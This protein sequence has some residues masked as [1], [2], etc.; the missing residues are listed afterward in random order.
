MRKGKASRILWAVAAVACVLLLREFAVGW[1]ALTLAQSHIYILEEAYKKLQADPAFPGSGFPE[2]E[3]IKANEGV[4]WV[5][6]HA[7]GG[8]LSGPGP[9]ST[10]N[11]DYSW[12][13]YNPNTKK[14]AAPATAARYYIH[15]R[16][17]M[18]H[19]NR[20]A[21][22]PT[23]KGSAAHNA[24]YMAH[25]LA[26]M[27]VPYHLTGMP[28][29]E[30]LA[31]IEAGDFMLGEDIVGP[32]GKGPENWKNVMLAWKN[33]YANHPD[34][35]WFDPWYWNGKEGIAPSHV[36]ATVLPKAI[37]LA[38]QFM[39][40]YEESTHLLWELNYGPTWVGTSG[41]LRG[42]AEGFEPQQIRNGN[43]NPLNIENLAIRSAM[44][45]RQNQKDWWGFF[46]NAGVAD[47]Y[48]HAV[49]NVF[50]AWRASFSALRASFSVEPDPETQENKL[51][52]TVKNVENAETSKNVTIK[53]TVRG[54]VLNGPDHHVLGDL[55]PG[56]EEKIED[57]WTIENPDR[58]TTVLI[59]VTGA[60]SKTPDSGV[61]FKEDTVR[62]LIPTSVD[63]VPS[64]VDRQEKLWKLEISVK[65]FKGQPVDQGD[66]HFRATGGSFAPQ[67]SLLEYQKTLDRGRTVKGWKETDE[68][69]HQI[70]V[71]YL[72]DK[73]DPTVPDE[74]YQES[75]VIISLPPESLELS[76]VFVIDASGS[77][78]GTKLASAK[79]A[80]RAALAQY[81]GISDKEEW[82]LYVFFNCGDCRLLQSFT[83]DPRQI[84]N[85]LTFNAAG[86]TPIAYSMQV[87]SNYLRK[88]ARG[89]KGRI[90]LLSDGGESCRG[91]PVEA[92][93]GIFERKEYF[94]LGN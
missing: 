71:R 35:D 75:E 15:L 8:F 92:A 39:S 45:T 56:V 61:T 11:S 58:N 19:I 42:Y 62:L 86:G 60:F 6:S 38:R 55:G 83:S 43:G 73:A 3:A 48:D 64:L 32:T 49:T 80:V 29:A 63:I 44:V 1:G 22:D 53:V 33:Y 65:D 90:I 2:L 7:E 18:D 30:A 74:K 31:K 34:A 70:T 94:D 17:H 68:N 36:A 54:A 13:Y 46:N 47:A 93:K 40:G 50:T 9:D 67:G 4:N 16:K 41:K 72:G 12:H 51:I 69:R 10:G 59:E 76:T 27:S 25:F 79:A 82:A 37:P 21:Q 28:A 87:A 57:I 85:K 84:T 52:V 78:R 66:V 77:M 89:K 20:L 81:Q 14:G 24:A 26:D 5:A 88:S 23:A 91:D